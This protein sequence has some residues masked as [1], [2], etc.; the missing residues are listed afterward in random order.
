MEII[1]G[2]AISEKI[3]NELRQELENDNRTSPGVAFVRV[4]ED[5]ASISYVNK[6]KKSPPASGLKAIFMFS[7]KASLKRN[8]WQKSTA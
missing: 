2:K 4:G 1:D 6:S 7:P 8:S 5:P 3:L